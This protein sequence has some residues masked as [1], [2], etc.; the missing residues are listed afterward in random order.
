MCAQISGLINPVIKRSNPF[1]ISLISVLILAVVSAVVSRLLGYREAALV[2]LMLVSLQ[3]MI[4][5]FI[6]VLITAVVS[7]LVWNFFLIPP[8]LTFHISNAED[9]LLF[10]MYFLIALINAVLTNRIRKAEKHL[11]EKEERSNAVRLYNTVFSSLS[12][13][14]KT[15]VSAMMTAI[16]TLKEGNNTMSEV[17]KNE[18]LTEMD[19]SLDR[20]NHQIE[21]LLNMGRI[22]S[23]FLKVRP[24]WC[25]MNETING[26]IRKFFSSGGKS[27]IRYISDSRLP[28]FK[29]DRGFL[30]QILYNILYN[31]LQYTPPGEEVKLE[32]SFTDKDLHIRISD[33]GP[34][35][36]ETELQSVFEKFKRLSNSKPGGSGLGLA[37]ARGFT[38]AQNGRIY[39]GNNPEGGAT[40]NMVIPVEMSFANQ[41]K[42][43]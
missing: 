39:I 1:L 24:D 6:S 2:M 15:P 8:T 33:K 13:E 11:A 41:L 14:L 20:L 21:N 42:N 23:G 36:P 37:I 27:N 28:L 29:T 9:A 4:F 32:V 18:I 3:A 34:G 10:F 40:V 38:E 22:E 35:F 30:E 25:D 16:D 43:E 26:L 31:A 17:Q 5:D 12:H 7:A 19:I